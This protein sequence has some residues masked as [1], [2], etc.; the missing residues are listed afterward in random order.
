MLIIYTKAGVL[1]CPFSLYSTRYWPINISYH[2][3]I[4][5]I[6]LQDSLSSIWKSSLT[7]LVHS[8]PGAQI[9]GGNTPTLLWNIWKTR[10]L[11]F[12]QIY[13]APGRQKSKK[14][15]DK[16]YFITKMCLQ[17]C[18]LVSNVWLIPLKQYKDTYLGYLNVPDFCFLKLPE[19]FLN[20]RILLNVP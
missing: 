15:N 17:Y 14:S 3:N 16:E 1:S 12:D 10:N 7:C 6:Q 19:M 4:F 11:N 9:I 5:K 20:L 13:F 2:F 8:L 18:V